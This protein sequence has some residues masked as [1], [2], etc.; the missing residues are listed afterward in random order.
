MSITNVP[1]S[2]MVDHN[3][4]SY[5]FRNKLINGDMRI[6]QRNV[7]TAV[8][9]VVDRAVGV[10]PSKYC[11]DRWKLSNQ[12]GSETTPL[13]AQRVDITGTDPN[14]EFPYALRIT[15]RPAG[16]TLPSYAGGELAQINQYIESENCKPLVG[17]Q[18]VLS[19][20]IR[21]NTNINVNWVVLWA[22]RGVDKWVGAVTGDSTTD[23]SFASGNF[24]ATTT[25]TTFTSPPFTVPVG[26]RNGI[27][28][29]LQMGAG[30][31]APKL[32]DITGVQLEIGPIATP[33]EHR[34]IATELALC[35]RYYEKSYDLNT[36]PGTAMGIS[37]IAAPNFGL[38]QCTVAGGSF[39][40]AV[41]T[42]SY[43]ASIYTGT[44]FKVDKFKTPTVVT[45]D[46]HTG[47]PGCFNLGQSDVS[48]NT[49]YYFTYKFGTPSNGRTVSGGVEP[50]TTGFSFSCYP[51]T[52]NGMDWAWGF[53]WTA[54]ADI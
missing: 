27:R 30:F 6:D 49:N 33:F 48:T 11:V 39:S 29:V 38:T 10:Y 13:V 14:G 19:A 20:R 3:I 34:P 35:Q 26:A 32:V 15:G 37:V 24:A 18:M 45:Y 21:A 43:G 51:W 31:D 54:D 52:P 8:N 46:T 12:W 1:A 4:G 44:N 47:T 9:I 28:V 41:P 40:Y 36:K 53:Y 42:K 22:G 2:R 16:T 7:G 17:K 5:C 50:N 25:P 23:Q